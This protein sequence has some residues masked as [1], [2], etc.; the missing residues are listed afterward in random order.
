MQ[1]QK[2]KYKQDGVTK[3]YVC[4]VNSVQHGAEYTICGIA[5]PDT[6]L[7]DDDCVHIGNSYTGVLKEVTCPNC[8]R[9]INFIKN[10]D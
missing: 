9:F 10:M 5:I 2:M 6:T 1:L 8:I 3:T 4:A 7:K